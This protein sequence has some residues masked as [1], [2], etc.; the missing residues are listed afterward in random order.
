[1]AADVADDAQP[2]VEVDGDR[3]VGAVE[4]RAVAADER[5]AEESV[6]RGAVLGGRGCRKAG[7]K[8][9]QK[10]EFA[11]VPPPEEVANIL[12]SHGV[13]EGRASLQATVRFL[14]RGD[15]GRSGLSRALWMTQ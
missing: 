4:V 3:A 13:A 9:C 2:V 8:Q 1:M 12:F 10:R 11:H 6:G 15:Y 5:V 7:Q 14:A